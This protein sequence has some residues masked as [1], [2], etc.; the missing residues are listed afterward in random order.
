MSDE[1]RRAIHADDESGGLIVTQL[2]PAGAGALAGLQVGD[3]ITHLGSKQL[4]GATQLADAGRPS[5]RLPLLMRVVRDGVP[6]FVA[7]TG[8]TAR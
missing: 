8:A 3:L 5:T 7:I 4:Y 6:Q 1:I 2:R